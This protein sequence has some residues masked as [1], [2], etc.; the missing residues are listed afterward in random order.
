MP[1]M[2]SRSTHRCFTDALEARPACDALQS[3]GQSPIAFSPALLQSPNKT[4]DIL[5]SNTVD[6]ICLY[7]I[8]YLKFFTIRPMAGVCHLK[9]EG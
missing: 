3:G 2:S 6:T 7:K 4:Y 1:T 5:I 8:R 9:N